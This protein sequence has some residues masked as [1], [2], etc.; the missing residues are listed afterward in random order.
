MNTPAKVMVLMSTYNGQYFLQEQL[1]SIY[2]QEGVNYS[3]L[4]R[5]DGS[6][7]KT[8]ALLDQEQAKGRLQWYSGMNLGPAKSFWDLV[9]NAQDSDYYA[10]SDQDDVWLKD[11]LKSAINKMCNTSEPALYF[12]QTQLVNEKLEKLKNVKLAPYLTYGEALVNQFI[13][14]CTMVFNKA[15][16]NELL[17]YTPQYLRMHDLWIYDVALAIGAKVYFDPT[18]HILYRQHSHNTVGQVN[19]LKFNLKSRFTHIKANEHIRL[20]TAQ[21]LWKGYADHMVPKNKELTWKIINYKTNFKIK[22]ELIFSKHLKCANPT[23]AITSR[24]ALL[25]NRF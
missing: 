12:C 8:T 11:K 18:P 22:W 4:V 10:F 2:N 24:I 1:N 16:R 7:D 15:L 20:R 25:L 9:I 17:L 3:L 21:E 5:D 6:K 23:I 13:S 14:G 19:S